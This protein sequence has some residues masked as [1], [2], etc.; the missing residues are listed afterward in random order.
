MGASTSSSSSK[1]PVFD[2]KEDGE[3]AVPAANPG[4]ATLLPC[5]G[6][7]D[8]WLPMQPPRS[9]IFQV[10]GMGREEQVGRAVPKLL[11][12]YLRDPPRHLAKCSGQTLVAALGAGVGGGWLFGSEE[13]GEKTH[14]G[15]GVSIL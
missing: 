11:T 3:C 2:E 9:F 8:V 5:P 7:G 10:G 6:G 12:E 1:K 14:L 4:Q 15:R 13:R